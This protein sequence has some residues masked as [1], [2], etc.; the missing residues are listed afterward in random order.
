MMTSARQQRAKGW[1]HTVWVQIFEPPLPWLCDLCIFLNLS[2]QQFLHHLKWVWGCMGGGVRG[3]GVGEEGL[4][5][6]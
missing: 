2:V 6:L 3:G 5:P 4:P 1:I